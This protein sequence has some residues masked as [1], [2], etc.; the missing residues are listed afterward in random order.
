[1]SLAPTAVDLTAARDAADLRALV[2]DPGSPAAAELFTR[3]D[4]LLVFSRHHWLVFRGEYRVRADLRA[5]VDD[6]RGR[7]PAD[8]ADDEAELLL[9]FAALDAAAVGLEQLREVIT[10]TEVR[11]VLTTRLGSYLAVLGQVPRDLGR[12]GLLELADRVRELRPR[13]EELCYRYSDIDGKAWYRAE[14]LI[15]R[16]RVD[17]ATLP[18]TLGAVLRD[19]HPDLPEGPAADRLAAATAATLAQHGETAPLLRLIM[20]AAVLD[21]DLRVDHATI[22]CTRGY[23]LDT[24][25]LMTGSEAFFTETVLRP[26]LDL[27]PY[28]EQIGHDSDARLQKT[29][30]ARMLKLK[31]KATGAFYGSGCM[32]GRFVEK[33]AD[34]MIF[35]NEDAHYRGHQSVGCSTGGRAAYPVRYE[36]DGVRHELPPM[37]GD[38]RMVRLSH[39][40]AQLFTPD[41]LVHVIRYA[42]C[43]RVVVEE[44]LRLRGHVLTSATGGLD[45]HGRDGARNALAASA[46][47]EVEG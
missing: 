46:T 14:G 9:C 31:R 41:E 26:E 12:L 23:L 11:G 4:R 16:S 40:P 34:F 21:P 18:L 30:R 15:P 22:T 43:V 29:V 35:R 5:V 28:A 25:E 39:D 7:P 38:F 17:H 10:A 33:G 44:T 8:W 45:R 47:A 24:P 20:A 19:A 37:M 42:A 3:C 27:S 2:G 1:M 36:R 13:A 32:A 6:L